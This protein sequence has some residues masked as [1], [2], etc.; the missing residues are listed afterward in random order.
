MGRRGQR[1][2]GM[3]QQPALLL[4]FIIAL[5]TAMAGRLAWLQLA[6]G[7][8]NR[9][10]ADEN[11][12]RLV[13]RS[14]MRGRLLDRRGRLMA[15]N[16][17]T[18]NL[19]LL[20]K[21][22]NDARWQQLQPRLA[23]LLQ[24]PAD[25]LNHQRQSGLNP[26]GYRIELI[27]DLKPDQVLRLKEQQVNLQ[28]L[29]VDQDY[30]R[31]YTY[32]A[33]G[34]HVLGY[35]SPITDA[36]YQYLEEKGYRI[37][38]RIGRIGIE[39]VY[40]NHLRGEWG[41]QQLEVNAAGEVQRVL[42]DKQAKAGK[43]LTLTL[44]LDLQ[45]AADEALGTVAKGAIVALDPRTGAVRAMASKPN[46][47]PNIFSRNINT[48]EWKFLNRTE[49]PLLNRALQGFPPAS[50]F[51]I[52]TTAAGIES[53]L[54]NAKSTL[55]TFNSFCYA[56]MCYGDHGSFVAIGFPLAL[57]VSSNS[58]YYQVG[59]KVGEAELF[60]AARRFGYGS[61]TGIELKTEESPGLLGDAAWK[62]QVL[63]EAWTPVDTITSAIGQG[64][65]QVTPLQMARLYA[66]VANGGNL[67]TPHLVEGKHVPKPQ[68]MGL[69]ADT[70]KMLHQGLR[71]AVTEGTAKVLADPN[72]PAVAG[73]T[74][75]GEDPPRPDH[76]WFGGYAPAEKPQL[77]I[78]AFAENS[79]GYGGTVSAPMV[80]KLMEVFFKKMPAQAALTNSG[81]KPTTWP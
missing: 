37:Q 59:L 38:D 10:L 64:A 31:S 79:G 3:D 26:D 40:E 30:R 5:L 74:G 52:V 27:A 18:Y 62:K 17:L 72:L 44:D 54:M 19:Y 23:N 6:H 2:S 7:S 4:I 75:T 46:Y 60:K 77:V 50:T 36:E 70:I 35:T 11:R 21:E 49:A 12:V 14:P 24:I 1:F 67:V 48:A 69:K 66:A 39:A 29:Q 45:R 56:G 34:A 65:L 78:V 51:K 43:D 20:P 53:G 71:R 28:G 80:K 61:Y 57:A 15:G 68:G 58:F 13:P 22:L 73:K 41:G 76:A 9:V 32:G 16:R 81:A 63:K 8:E 33:L 25:R 47:D 55:P 42:G